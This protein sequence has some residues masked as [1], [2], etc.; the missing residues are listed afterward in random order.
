MITTTNLTAAYGVTITVKYPTGTI[1]MRERNYLTVSCDADDYYLKKIT[2]AGKTINFGRYSLFDGPMTLDVTPYYAK[3]YS[4]V[5]IS[6]VVE[7]QDEVDE[8]F[9]IDFYIDKVD[10]YS[11]FLELCPNVALTLRMRV[12]CRQIV[13]CGTEIKSP[14]RYLQPCETATD[15]AGTSTRWRACRM[16]H[17][18]RP[19]SG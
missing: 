1:F 15:L 2:L 6:L 4:F 13:C 3:L 14:H 17:I 7:N 5:N 18:D 12:S 9:T 8:T 11:P 10:G 19:T 16:L